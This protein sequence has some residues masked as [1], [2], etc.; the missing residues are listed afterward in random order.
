MRILYILL[1]YIFTIPLYSNTKF[2]SGMEFNLSIIEIKSKFPIP[3]SYFFAN[4][5]IYAGLITTQNIG[6]NQLTLSLL[7]GIAISQNINFPTSEYNFNFYFHEAYLRYDGLSVSINL[8]KSLLGWGLGEIRQFSFL[9]NDSFQDEQN[10][11]YNTEMLYR[12]NATLLSLGVAIDTESLDILEKP[13]WYKTWMYIKYDHTDFT[14][15]SSIIMTWDTIKDYSLKVAIDFQY[16]LPKG[17]ELYGSFAYSI[18]QDNKLGDFDDLDILAALKYEY[19]YNENFRI[20]P[21]MEYV[22][23]QEDNLLSTGITMLIYQLDVNFFYVYTH[24]KDNEDKNS[25]LTKLKWNV[26]NHFN[27]RFEHQIFFEKEQNINFNNTFLL[28]MEVLF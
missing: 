3:E 10:R 5:G 6:F 22:W 14:V 9:Q 17:F 19:I 8:G 28:G 16:F 1:F 21:L 23:D 15:L 27:L 11:F 12:N 2:A 24:T 26:N 4:T 20:I 7:P 13:D 25:I 18:L